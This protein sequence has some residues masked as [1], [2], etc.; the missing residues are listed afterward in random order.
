MKPILISSGEPAGIGPDLCLQLTNTEWPVVVLADINVLKTRALQLGLSIE[1]IHY[2]PHLVAKKNQ[3]VV[4]PLACP[5]PVTTGKPNPNNAGYVIELLSIAIDRCLSG[6]FSALVTAPVHKGVINE[7]GIPFT[8]H[9]EFLAERCQVDGVVMMLVSPHFKVALVT[10]H[11][12]LR[13]VPAAITPALISQ[14]VI[15]LHNALWQD[16]GIKKP[17]IAVTGLNP[18]AGESGYLG[19]EEIEVIIPTLQQLQQQGLMVDGP[20]PADTLFTEKYL[21]QYDVMVAMYHDQ[22]LPVLKYSGFGHAVNVTLGLPIIR[23]SVDHGTAFELAGTGRAEVGSLI[24]AIRHA[25]T[26]ARVRASFLPR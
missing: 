2:A 26:S 22:G 23:T 11:L 5:H 10:T 15:K 9:T 3:L 8:G 16:Y 7:G 20:F 14:V 17:R 18:H 12:P 4:L 21:K 19:R 6:E 25:A 13:A 1:L 24:E